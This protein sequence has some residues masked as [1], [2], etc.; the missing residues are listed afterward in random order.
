MRNSFVLK[1]IFVLS[2]LVGYAYPLQAA[3]K[4]VYMGG[5]VDLIGGTQRC[6]GQA[7]G[8]E[9]CCSDYVSGAYYREIG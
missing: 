8:A 3:E 1:I 6:H 5:T 2:I 7:R 4:S 9:D